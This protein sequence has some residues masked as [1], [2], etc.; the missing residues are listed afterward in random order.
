LNVY[1]KETRKIIMRELADFLGVSEPIPESWEGAPVLDRKE[2]CFFAMEEKRQKTDIE[3][4]WNVFADAI[5]LADQRNAASEET[6]LQSFN[7]ALRQTGIAWNLTMGL[8]WIRPW[9]FMSLDPRFKE[10]MSQCLCNGSSFSGNKGD[11]TAEEYLRHLGS[12]GSPYCPKE[13]TAENYL[14]FLDYWDLLFKRDLQLAYSFPEFSL[15]AMQP[16]RPWISVPEKNPIAAFNTIANPELYYGWRSAVLRCIKEFCYAKNS[17]VFSRQGFLDEYEIQFRRAS[18]SQ[19]VTAN[20]L[21][22]IND[23]ET[24]RK[25]EFLDGENYRFL[26]L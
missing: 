21:R 9:C 2:P 24:D 13:C 8:C 5:H 11:V 1:K 26:K 10:Y 18:K 17:D 4:L 3:T 15:L 22:I 19:S 12:E 7:G 14:A 16:W 23:L 25:L 6:F 20:I